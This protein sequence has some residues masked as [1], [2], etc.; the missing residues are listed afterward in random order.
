MTNNPKILIVDDDM[1]TREMYVDVFRSASY[2][3]F[4]AKDGLEGLDV[5]AREH[6][7]VIFTGIIMPRMDGFTLIE[8]LKKNVATATTPVVVNSHLGREEDQRHANELGARDFIVRDLTPPRDVVERIS[9]ML[10][11]GEYAIDFDP[12][13]MDAQ[14]LARDLHVG[15]FFQCDGDRKMLLKLRVHDPKNKTFIARFEC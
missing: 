11:G 12:Y 13:A 3:V 15:N 10:A 6:P 5:A 9:A 2:T 8:A 14:R 1:D 7:D 4:S